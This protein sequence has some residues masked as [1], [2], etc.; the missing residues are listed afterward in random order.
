MSTSD[1]I[2]A[3]PNACVPG[4]WPAVDATAR[5]LLAARS[6]GRTVII[7]RDSSGDAGA[8]SV[9][10]GKHGRLTG[11][12]PDDATIVAELTPTPVE[13]VEKK[14]PSLFFGTDL[15][16]RLRAEGVDSL[17]VAGTSTSGCVRASVVDAFSH[18]FA[19]T[20]VEDCVFDRS[21]TSHAVTLFEI[22]QKY[23]DVASLD[24]ALAALSA[25]RPAR[26]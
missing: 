6:T 26:H 4:A 21:P 15:A 23:G 5:L 12:R 9:W 17:V 3:Y 2:T 16:G 20:V 8:D 18:G 1:A 22:D 7:S 25:P 11:R 14:V 10:H 13:L 19:V 24:E